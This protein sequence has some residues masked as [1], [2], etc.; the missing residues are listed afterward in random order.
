[1]N[2]LVAA[3]VKNRKLPLRLIATTICIILVFSSVAALNFMSASK[4]SSTPKTIIELQTSLPN[5]CITADQAIQTATPYI[6]QYA[7]QNNRAITEIKA[8]FKNSTSFLFWNE[9]ECVPSE[10]DFP[11]GNGIGYVWNVTFTFQAIAPASVVG[12]GQSALQL[13]VTGF[14]V[15]IWA[16]SGQ[17]KLEGPIIIVNQPNLYEGFQVVVNQGEDA[18]SK[19]Y[20]PAEQALQMSIPYINRYAAENNRTVIEIK[21]GFSMVFDLNGK[22][23]GSCEVY[24]QWAVYAFFDKSVLTDPSGVSCF[25]PELSHIYGYAVGIWADTAQVESHHEQG[26]M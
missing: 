7:T 11:N 5:G 23:D 22:R 15:S 3:K 18:L 16:Y 2:C 24:P 20:I 25:D 26:V 19:S 6:N 10:S 17:I 21:A 14:L 8:I 9:G 12:D 1:V 4:A 13:E